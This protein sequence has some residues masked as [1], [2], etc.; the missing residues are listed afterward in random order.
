MADLLFAVA[1]FALI[2]A[3][4][5]YWT[6]LQCGHSVREGAILGAL[7]GPLG[8]ILIPMLEICQQSKISRSENWRKPAA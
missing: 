2:F 3:A 5:G 1:F 7:L 4:V 6:A 8:V